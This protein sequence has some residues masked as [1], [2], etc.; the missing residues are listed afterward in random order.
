MSAPSV[1]ERIR[2]LDAYAP[3]LSIAEIQRRHG[4]A[5]VIKLAS[6]ENPLGASP[7]AQEAVRRNAGLAFRYP[8]G[9]NP[10]LREALAR[11][12]GVAPERIVVGNGSDEIIDLLIRMLAADGEHNIVCCEPCFS[13][14]PIQA[15]VAGVRLRRRPLRED[16]SQDLDGLAD[17][18]DGATRLVFVTTPDNPSGYRPPR[19]EVLRLARRLAEKAP[20]ALLVVDEAY[21]DFAEDEAAASLLL[22]GEL[23]ENVAILRTFSK[24]WGLAG[25]RLGYGVVPPAIADGFW[26]SRLPF[27]V[28]VLAEEAALA[29]ME[30]TAFRAA[31]LTTVR[32]GR[33]ALAEGLTRL[34]CQVWP[35]EANFLM[36]RLPEGHDAR[37]CFEG[38]LRRGIIIRPLRSYGLPEHLRVSVGTPEE[39]AAFLRALEQELGA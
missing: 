7:L 33:R 6:N 16:F 30:D 22:A 31:T 18:A 14:Y 25:L 27:S 11:L 4:L 1:L 20:G 3:G 28:N 37:V 38:L 12:H 17:L 10:R 8:Q 5:K 24:S 21:M 32:E 19:E 39:N 15:R 9:G 34:G 13:I 23:P 29:A 35:S 26:R 36:F 2:A